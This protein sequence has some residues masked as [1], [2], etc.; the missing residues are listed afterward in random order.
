MKL[1]RKVSRPFWWCYLFHGAKHTRQVCSHGC[2]YCLLC[3]QG[4]GCESPVRAVWEEN[5]WHKLFP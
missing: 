5:L 1:M 4:S 3:Q 2:W